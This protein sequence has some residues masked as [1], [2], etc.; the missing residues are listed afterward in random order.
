MYSLLGG[1][2]FSDLEFFYNYSGTE[3]NTVISVIKTHAYNKSC[4]SNI[5]A[6]LK[7][8]LYDINLLKQKQQK[9]EKCAVAHN[10]LK[11]ALIKI[12]DNEKYIEWYK[13]SYDNNEIIDVNK[14]VFFNM[15][16]FEYLGCNKSNIVL[17]SYNIYNIICSPCI[18]ILSPIFYFIIPYFFLVYKLKLN[19]SFSTFIKILFKS[20]TTLS[21]SQNKLMSLQ[22][23]SYVLSLFLYFQG[24]F[25]TIEISKSSYKICNHINENMKGVFEYLK[26]GLLIVN[27]YNST[28][29]SF[30]SVL[31][32]PL[33]DTN[34]INFGEHLYRY[35]NIDLSDLNKLLYSIDE[36]LEWFS[37]Y[38]F[39]YTNNL[40][41]SSYVEN[42]DSYIFSKDVHHVQIHDAITNDFVLKNKSCIITGPNAAGKSTF[43]KALSINVILS[44]TYGIC[45]ASEFIHTPFYFITTQI[46]IPDT[47][48]KESLFQAEMNRCKYILDII[49][50][51]P[52]THKCFI[53]MDEIFNS[54][55]IIEGIS[56]AY[57]ILEK[58]LSYDTNT[59][60][61]TTH[62][63][64]LTKIKNFYKFKM[65][66]NLS[67]PTISYPY[68]LSK[69]VSKQYIALELLKSKFDE[70]IIN[71][72]IE[73]KSKLIN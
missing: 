53:V 43:I 30:E 16:L 63:Q 2:V 44:Q 8:P 14:S 32:I 39:M 52:T 11:T 5:I 13:N 35:K 67:K 40:N 42:N 56:G 4:I 18:G 49:K 69:G 48:G 71:K 7:R 73:I 1:D 37:I 66:A 50:F 29:I 6:T 70:D 60:I 61:I 51:L 31:G 36:C 65:D 58:L 47:K 28:T 57:A 26:N 54:T 23:G 59:I 55:N 24:L 45:A 72:A 17:S 64:Y 62:F 15:K 10:E 33:F 19:I 38:N 34:S 22:L 46:N 68:K 3:D 41:F 21:F 27:T 12:K 25:N 20:L 9:L